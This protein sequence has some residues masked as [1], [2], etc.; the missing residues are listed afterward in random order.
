MR[1]EIIVVPYDS[2][3]RGARMGAGP[4]R[5]IDAGLAKRLSDGGHEVRVTTIELPP[6]S[7]YPEN[8]AAFELDRRIATAVSGAGAVEAFPIVLSGNCISC[9]GT[10]AGIGDRKL[11]AIWF[12]AHGDF[13]TPETT[14]SGFLDGMSLGILTGEC[15][16]S[17]AAT[18]PGFHPLS[19]D[20]VMLVGARH[21]DS[22]EDRSFSSSPI[23]RVTAEEARGGLDD[24][25]DRLRESYE[26]VYLHV[27]LD[28]L[29]PSEGSANTYATPNGL[30]FV[31]LR[32][33]VLSIVRKFRVRAMA[34]T[35][36]DP[37]ADTDGRICD[38]ALVLVTSA[39]DAT[40][41]IGMG[42][43]IS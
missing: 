43:R 21:F 10:T 42:P 35:A 33:A 23:T 11:G 6:N 41:E 31:D 16:S 15:W 13:N 7:F 36:Y 5:L 8:Q 17:V 29:D 28:V 20:R 40:G 22:A 24:Y 39:V 38:S 14:K 25:L 32:S 9:I 30:T 18:V 12:D 3:F 27:D 2:G 34:V 26:S 4:E 1:V 37:A 19:Q